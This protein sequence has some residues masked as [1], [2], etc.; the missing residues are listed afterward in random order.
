M[1][2]G[3][4]GDDL[5]GTSGNIANVVRVSLAVNGRHR[6]I[7]AAYATNDNGGVSAKLRA[8]QWANGAFRDDGDLVQSATNLQWGNHS[9]AIDADGNVIVVWTANQGVPQIRKFLTA[10]NQWSVN[11]PTCTPAPCPSVVLAAN[12]SGQVAIVQRWWGAGELPKVARG[13]IA[14]PLGPFEVISAKEADYF[15]L[16]E[17]ALDKNNRLSLSMT[18]RYANNSRIPESRVLR[19]VAAG[20]WQETVIQ[21]SPDFKFEPKFDKLTP[22]NGGG[23]AI[24]GPLTSECGFRTSAGTPMRYCTKSGVDFMTLK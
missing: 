7:V 9:A 8:Y 22:I 2:N 11:D 17:T 4:L 16:G 21:S 1:H 23:V 5:T 24:I 6:A 19:S 12:N 13:T 15:D 10:A 20:I 3:K 18:R 14:G